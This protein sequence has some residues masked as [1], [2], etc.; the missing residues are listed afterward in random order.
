[1]SPFHIQKIFFGERTKV[2]F[3]GR[4]TDSYGETAVGEYEMNSFRFDFKLRISIKAESEY[5]EE[6]ATV[7]YEA[8]LFLRSW[9]SCTTSTANS[10][11]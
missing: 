4:G 9:G 11:S 2:G 3:L 6:P 1:M 7:D 5:E 10:G 8:L